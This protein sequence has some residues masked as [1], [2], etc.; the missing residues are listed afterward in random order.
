[1][2]AQWP[3]IFSGPSFLPVLDTSAN[4]YLLPAKTCY[5]KFEKK[6]IQNPQK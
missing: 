3:F 5:Q 1:M 2:K 4:K 6:I